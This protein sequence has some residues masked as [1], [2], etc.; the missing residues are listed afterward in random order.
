MAHLLKEQ[1]HLVNFWD[2]LSNDEKSQLE[3]QI[4]KVDFTQARKWFEDSAHLQTSSPENLT[5]IPK[6][7]IFS[8]D[9]LSKTEMHEYWE[10]GLDAISRGEVAA[11]VL[12]GGQASRLGSAEPKGTIPLGLNVS[13]GDSL[14]GIQAAK[15]AL[16]QAAAGER[17]HEN[18]GKIHWLVMT[19]PGTEKATHSHVQ[20]LAKHH[21]FN[22]EDQVTIFSQDEIPAYDENGDFLL[23]T[24]HSLVASPNGNGGVYSALAPFLPKLKAKGIKYFHVYCVDNILCKVADPHFIG[25]AALNN[26]DVATKCVAK[27]KGELV[28]SVCL[29]SG[30]PRV[31]EYSELGAELA[32]QKTAD[33]SYLFGAGSIANHFFSMEFMERICSSGS[34]SLP[35]HRAHKKIAYID[36][37]SGEQIKPTQPNGYK[38]ELFIF[39][40][41]EYARNFFIWQV[42]RSEEFS[43]LKNAESAGK[44][45]LSTCKNDLAA[46]NSKWLQHAGATIEENGKHFY[47]NT[48]ISYD[49]ENLQEL[50]GKSINQDLIDSDKIIAKHFVH[51]TDSIYD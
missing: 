38:L 34:I 16:L 18:N 11:L 24:K 10:A 40:V 21:G 6:E 7:R 51:N 50:R 49:G 9:K 39:D 41:F 28:G 19:S 48:L 22:F 27:Q 23:A 25:F 29:D 32:D 3:N 42:E 45:C 4:K 30:K 17:N 13:F 1:Q 33:G 12:A 37:K 20:K 8:T 35:Y 5:P 36:P 43:P 26:A 44:D 2:E 15:I 31:V 14:L 47:L 46:L